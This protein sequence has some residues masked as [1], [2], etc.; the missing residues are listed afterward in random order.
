[1][2]IRA[3]HR[4]HPVG[5]P[6]RAPH[7]LP[8][9]PG[10]RFA[11]LLLPGLI[12]RRHDHRLIAQVPDQ[13]PGD[14]A[15]DHT[16]SRVLVPHRVVEQPLHPIRR[17]IPRVLGQRPAVLPWQVADQPGDILPGLGKRLHP[18]EARRQPPVQRGQIRHRQ[19]T[20]YHRSRSRLTVFMPHNLMIL[21]R[22][23]S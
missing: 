18:R 11:L 12:Q 7:V 1:V 14:E 19:L 5:D 21:R 3:I 9:H 23:L 8:L 13:V 10:R 2:A 17:D 16:L 22:L 15:A 4:V 20:L 6:A